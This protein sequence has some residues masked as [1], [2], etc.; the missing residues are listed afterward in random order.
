MNVRAGSICHSL[1]K[2]HHSSNIMP[3]FLSMF[4]PGC[5]RCNRLMD[6]KIDKKFPKSKEKRKQLRSGRTI[7]ESLVIKI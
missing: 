3:G 1:K 5:I 4:E 7:D 2:S 6:V